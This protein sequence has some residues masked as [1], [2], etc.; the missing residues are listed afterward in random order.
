MIAEALASRQ[1]VG[2]PL[3][4]KIIEGHL[5]GIK[6]AFEVLQPS[7]VPLLICTGQAAI[8]FADVGGLLANIA[9]RQ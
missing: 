9:A 4:P 3:L 8:G 2:Q 6:Y 5:R 1:G 7:L